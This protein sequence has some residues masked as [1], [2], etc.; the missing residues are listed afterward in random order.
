M[1]DKGGVTRFERSAIRALERIAVANEELIRLAKDERDV[2]ESITGPPLCPHC[3]RLNPSIRSEG[4]SGEFA[5]FKLVAHCENCGQTFLAVSQ[6]W[7][8]FK[9]K[10]ELQEAGYGTS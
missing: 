5:D 10:E 8:C 3:G 6:G 4:G 2:G 1:G 7:L 9:T